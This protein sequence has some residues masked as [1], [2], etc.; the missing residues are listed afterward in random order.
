MSSRGMCLVAT[1]SVLQLAGYA[2]RICEEL[3]GLHRFS[4]ALFVLDPEPA[5]KLINYGQYDVLLVGEPCS[6]VDSG[7][8]RSL[9]AH[10]CDICR[11]Q[12]DACT[13]PRRAVDARGLLL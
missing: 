12:F 5:L 13:R 9:D 10:E 7:V 4:P 8:P 11:S 2:R 6:L 3:R 1:T